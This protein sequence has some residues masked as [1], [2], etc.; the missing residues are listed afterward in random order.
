MKC[1]EASGQ[2]SSAALAIAAQR[3]NSPM[4][5]GPD[6]GKNKIR[7]PGSAKGGEPS[8]EH[9]QRPRPAKLRAHRTLQHPALAKS[10]NRPVQHGRLGLE[11]AMH[12]QSK[13]GL[14]A[15]QMTGREPWLHEAALQQL[16]AAAPAID[17]Q[18]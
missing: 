3:A 6:T 13:S 7:K 16:A 9:Q 5:Y 11:P 1:T 2:R 18:R 14:G 15:F 12:G 4:P 8:V 17:E 10:R